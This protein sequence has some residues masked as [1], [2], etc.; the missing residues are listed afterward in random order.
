MAPYSSTP[1]SGAPGSALDA[2]RRR[3]TADRRRTT[4][5][6]NSSCFE[7]GN[8]ARSHRNNTRASSVVGSSACAA[9]GARTMSAINLSGLKNTAS[10]T[11]FKSK[12][13]TDSAN[14]N[15]Q[16]RSLSSR[17]P[18]A[19]RFRNCDLSPPPTPLSCRLKISEPSSAPLPSPAFPLALFDDHT[20]AAMPMVAFA[21][22][23]LIPTAPLS[24]SPSCSSPRP[25]GDDSAVTSPNC[26]R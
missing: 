10:S 11:W 1:F 24:P 3:Q 14:S 7:A 2:P 15:R 8:A 6:L 26:S 13:S 25:P 22:D 23:T 4:L 5:S 17:S 19:S 18:T 16:A 20:L 21:A 12:S 9:D